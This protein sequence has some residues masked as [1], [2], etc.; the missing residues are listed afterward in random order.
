MTTFGPIIVADQIELGA[1]V[2]LQKWFPTYLRE[3]ERNRGLDP[4]TIQDPI[5]FNSR[6]TTE[7]QPGEQLPKCV[8]ISP[9]LASRPAS[10]G[11]GNYR[12]S[13][14]L[15]VGVVFSDED[16][17]TARLKV[18]SYAAAIRAMILQKLRKETDIGIVDI[19]WID[20]SYEDLTIPGGLKQLK[21]AVVQFTVDIG[22]VV[23][24]RGGPDVPTPETSV[25]GIVETV[26]IDF[27]KE[28]IDA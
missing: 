22:N 27:I 21:A 1:Q 5:T 18:D 19:A 7:L 14:R 26:D 2:T 12:A 16:E 13:W 28:P 20:E 25:Y 8:I 17:E 6:N 10:D 11:A 15:G 23:T 4:N 9:G 3:L 24:K